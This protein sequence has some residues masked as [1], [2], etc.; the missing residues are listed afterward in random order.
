MNRPGAYGLSGSFYKCIKKAH[1]ND[2]SYLLFFEDDAVPILPPN[3][4]NNRINEVI[5]NMPNNKEDIYLL[6]IAVYCNTNK[7]DKLRWAKQNS[8]NYTSGTHA[9]YIGQ[10]SIKKLINHLKNNKIDLPIDEWLKKFNPWIWYGDLDET[11]MF[12]G[13]FKQ[14]DMNC[15][16]VFT[17]EG[18]INNKI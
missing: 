1:D 17:L 4:F 8:L 5:S 12:R 3:K 13:L 9:I 16:N 6:G 2:W 11:G 15:Q 18:P 14:I 7:N 10:K